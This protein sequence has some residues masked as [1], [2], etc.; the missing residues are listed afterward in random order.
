MI[1][2]FSILRLVLSAI[3]TE[4]LPN[5]IKRE[6]RANFR[7]PE[8]QSLPIQSV[9]S[10]IPYTGLTPGTLTHELEGGTFK[11]FKYYPISNLKV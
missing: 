7:F 9:G 8:S 2:G 3:V 11:P 1:R 5:N 6:I 10:P 4:L